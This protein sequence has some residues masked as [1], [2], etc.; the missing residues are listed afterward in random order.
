MSFLC[1]TTRRSRSRLGVLA[2]LFSIGLSGLNAQAP[3]EVEQRIRHIQ[4]AI[5]PAVIIEGEPPSTSTLAD[6]MAKLHVPGVSIA[7]IHDGRIEW[8]RGFG[9]AR[10]G[11]PAVTADTLF[12]AASISKPVTSLAVLHL[13]QSGRLD[14]DAD[15]NRYLKTWK[16]PANNFTEKTKVT[17]RE[18]LTHTAGMTV[19]GFP[20]YASDAALPTLV[21]VLNGAKPANTPPI[22]V[23]TV[24]GTNWR[25]SGGGFVV[26]QL[27]L[28]GV[29]S[30]PFPT[31]MHDIVLG[32]I[33]MTRSTY[34]QPLPRSRMGEAAMPYQRSG[35]PVAGGP[36]VY[37]EMAPAGLW[38]TPSDLARYA[39]EVQKTLAGSS[40]KVL[41]QS[42]AREMLTPGKNKWGLGV[43]TG[44]SAAHPYFT[45]SGANEG[46]QCDLV[47]YNNGDGAVVMTNSDSGGQL[48]SEVVRTIANEYKWPDFAP[49]ERK[50]ITLSTD[51][52][53]RYT[54]LYAMAPGMNMTITLADGQLI[55]QMSG[56]ERVPLY[57]E[58]ETMFF[59]KV[60]DAE[61][62]FPQSDTKGPASQ[63]ILHQ[64]G[65][66]MSAKRLDEAEAKKAADAAAAFDKRFK[67]QTPAPG[68]E[69]ALRRM[70][71]ELRI[72]KPNYDLMS[73]GLADATR[74]Q[75]SQLQPMVVA[76]GA[77]Q[78]VNFKGVGPGGADIYRVKFEKGSLE[79]RIWLSP[80]GKTKSANV[81]PSE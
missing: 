15:V 67:D 36:H 78:S 3:A 66:D 22:V 43:E 79:Y 50:E 33:G 16:V 30:L 48:A 23:D 72:G 41:S 13:V 27:V 1:L 73:P 39:V 63:L 68:S 46:F 57:A 20:G 77:L 59:P 81:R 40:N 38:T 54:G 37:P 62:E 32:P 56:Q 49:R 65:H 14:L 61:I 11:G 47:A 17:L 76:L 29:T 28:E 52:L 60:V 10:I 26:T 21:Q 58:S 8:A 12:Q 5:L 69:A 45:H 42:M 25:Y 35:Q 51:V 24:P 9:L 70:I 74:Q 2:L 75:L 71:E 55:S 4:D 34:E 80:D 18:L 7:V 44:G 6:R 19:H 31:M 64:N 53:A